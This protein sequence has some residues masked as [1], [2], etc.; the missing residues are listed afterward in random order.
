MTLSTNEQQVL[1]VLAE[2]DAVD[3]VDCARLCGMGPGMT[4]AAL[5]SL[6]SKGYAAPN[7]V[8]KGLGKKA[9]GTWSIT[10]DGLAL[11]RRP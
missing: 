6:T 7:M 2:K 11:L 8:R 1:D 10:P 4:E 3:P 9:D 5:R